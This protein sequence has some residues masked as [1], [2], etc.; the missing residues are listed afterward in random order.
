[1]TIAE[2]PVHRAI[3][4]GPDAWR[5][6]DF[7]G[8]SDWNYYLKP[9]TLAELDEAVRR[10]H[11]AKKDIASLTSADFPVPSFA[12]DAAML[13]H[14]LEHGRGF[15]VI[16]GLRIDGYSDMDACLMYWGIASFLGAALPQ[17]VK[18]DRLYAVR[19]EGYNIAREYGAAGVRFSKTA[20]GLG[21]HTDSAPV[22]RGHTPD[23]VGLLALQ[24][25]K[26]GGETA[27]VSAATIHNVIFEE[28][29]DYLER[30]YRGYYF[31]RRAE[32]KPGEPAVLFAPIF[33]YDSR[34]KI[35]HF[36]FYIYRA[37]EITGVPLS[38]ADA[39]PLEFLESVTQ[40]PEL[41]VLFGMERGDMQFVNNT[42]LLHSRTAFEDHPEPERRRHLVRL[43]LQYESWS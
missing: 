9:E 34:L 14:E 41:P 21:F 19:D 7:S 1:M 20:S 30:L 2:T 42:S 8:P 18:G 31:D 16:K 26:S 3:L 11:A 10:I 24:T 25:A 4:T 5:R 12:P 37:P 28:R 40:R 36:P 13:R 23:V 33:T 39:E 22:F 38:A 32:L 27:I 6:S 29:P 15:V 35:R 17:N 43:W